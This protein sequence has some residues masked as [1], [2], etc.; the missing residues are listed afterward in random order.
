MLRLSWSGGKTL[1]ALVWAPHTTSC[2][3]ST[4]RDGWRVFTCHRARAHFSAFVALPSRIVNIVD[5]IVRVVRSRHIPLRLS[6]FTPASLRELFP[7]RNIL[8]PHTLT[9][10]LFPHLHHEPYPVSLF[11]NSHAAGPPAFSKHPPTSQLIRGAYS[12]VSQACYSTLTLPVELARHECRFK[13]QKLEDIRDSRAAVLGSL[14]HLRDNLDS[15]LAMKSTEER[16]DGIQQFVDQFQRVLREEHE[17]VTS[18]TMGPLE[19][20]FVLTDTVLPQHVSSHN[21]HIAQLGLRRP[22]RLTL[23][24]P[25][26]AFLPPLALLAARSLYNSRDSLHQMAVDAVATLKGFWEDWLLGPLKEVVKTV[27][28]G[29]DEG[30]IITKESVKADLEVCRIPLVNPIILTNM[31]VVFGANGVV[32]CQREIELYAR[33]NGC[34]LPTDPTRRPHTRHANLRRRH[35]EP[36]QVRRRRHS[37]PHPPG[38]GAES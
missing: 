7:S 16:L 27:R 3:V 25:K 4:F 5:T 19:F 29:G 9:V 36:T 11:S 32:A 10:A 33:T 34:A 17:A 13:R 26:L 21:A 1:N 8:R 30:V 6:V 14:V 2:K 35:Q 24:W 23:I 15:V 31:H 12:R 37:A 20:S 22:S 38:P 28:A 18:D